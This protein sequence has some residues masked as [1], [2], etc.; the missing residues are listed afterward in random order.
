MSLKSSSSR[1][2][3]VIKVNTTRQ[4]PRSTHAQYDQFLYYWHRLF[5]SVEKA[6]KASKKIVIFRFNIESGEFEKN[7]D[8]ITSACNDSGI[9]GGQCNQVFEMLKLTETINFATMSNRLLTKQIYS[10]LF[11]IFLP[12]IGYIQICFCYES[13]FQKKINQCLEARVTTIKSHQ[14]SFNKTIFKKKGWFWQIDD[15]GGYQV[16]AKTSE[17]MNQQILKTQKEAELK[18]IEEQQKFPGRGFKDQ[19]LMTLN[20]DKGDDDKSEVADDCEKYSDYGPGRLCYEGQQINTGPGKDIKEKSGYQ[21]RKERSSNK[22]S[23]VSSYNNSSNSVDQ[24]DSLKSCLSKKIS[25][26]TP[27]IK[28]MDDLR[29]TTQ[30]QQE[31]PKSKF[32]P[33][34]A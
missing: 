9:D 31:P 11:C 33:G 34:R 19:N 22:T 17:K 23:N 2:E 8:L 28:D 12:I 26:V 15:D 21:N 1:Q 4:T 10:I 13:H 29:S 25:K 7:M 27:I 3:Q 6:P 18:K 20:S 30:Y 16:F 5:R 32:N 14:K 24:S